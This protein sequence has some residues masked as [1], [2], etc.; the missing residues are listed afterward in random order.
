MGHKPTTMRAIVEKEAAAAIATPEDVPPLA[1]EYITI[2][3][4]SGRMLLI[5]SHR[6][7]PA[8]FSIIEGI[9]LERFR[10]APM[11]REALDRWF[12]QY[13]L[14]WE[15]GRVATLSQWQGHLQNQIAGL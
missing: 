4:E 12:T 9:Q 3:F 8:A 7:Q 11:C 2:K 1:D 13:N 6:S 15:D 5:K 14:E 10:H